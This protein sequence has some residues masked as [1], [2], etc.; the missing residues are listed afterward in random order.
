MF[1]LVDMKRLREGLV[2]AAKV[3][4]CIGAVITTICGIANYFDNGKSPPKNQNNQCYESSWNQYDGEIPQERMYQSD[5]GNCSGVG[6]I[7]NGLSNIIERIK[8]NRKRKDPTYMPYVPYGPT[9][10]ECKNGDA[11]VLP[12]PILTHTQKLNHQNECMVNPYYAYN[13]PYAIMQHHQQQYPYY[14]YNNLGGNNMYGNNFM[15]YENYPLLNNT[16][17]VGY[18]VDFGNPTSY[19]RYNYMIEN[20]YNNITMEQQIRYAVSQIPEPPKPNILS[21]DINASF[22]NKDNYG[23]FILPKFFNQYDPIQVNYIKYMN[24]VNNCINEILMN[25]GNIPLNN[26]LYA[27][28]NVPDVNGWMLCENEGGI[29][30]RKLKNVNTGECYPIPNDFIIPSELSLTMVAQLYGEQFKRDLPSVNSYDSSFWNTNK[31]YEEMLNRTPQ[32]YKDSCVDMGPQFKDCKFGDSLK[33]G[34]F[35]ALPEKDSTIYRIQQEYT[36]GPELETTGL[37]DERLFAKERAEMY[38]NYNNTH[39]DIVNMVNKYNDWERNYINE[40]PYQSLFLPSNSMIP[41]YRKQNPF[42]NNNNNPIW[43][44]PNFRFD[45]LYYNNVNPMCRAMYENHWRTNGI[46]PTTSNNWFDSSYDVL[47][48]NWTNMRFDNNNNPYYGNTQ[49]FGGP[50]D[51]SYQQMCQQ[52]QQN[53]YSLNNMN[54]SDNPYST[55]NFVSP[56]LRNLNPCVSSPYEMIQGLFADKNNS[57]FFYSDAEMESFERGNFNTPSNHGYMNLG[58][59]LNNNKFIETNERWQNGRFIV[60]ASTGVKYWVSDM[61]NMCINDLGNI[62]ELVVSMPN[63]VKRAEAVLGGGDFATFNPNLNNTNPFIRNT[64][65]NPNGVSWSGTQS[66]LNAFVGGK[67]VI[68]PNTHEPFQLANGVTLENIPTAC[69]GNYELIAGLHANLM[70]KVDKYNDPIV[71]KE[72]L[73]EAYDVTSNMKNNNEITCGNS[74]KE[75]EDFFGNQIKVKN[76]KPEI[77]HESKFDENGREIIKVDKYDN[78]YFRNYK[79]EEFVD[80]KGGEI[81]S[82]PCTAPLLSAEELLRNAMNNPEVYG[83]AIKK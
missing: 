73:N 52:I 9:Q 37:Y 34:Y 10:Y 19:A 4:G 32:I 11:F 15:G 1:N 62:D 38:R 26:N 64:M 49:I 66:P 83:N 67:I 50:T 5:K 2:V 48:N 63:H 27:K 60:N 79:G 16:N 80:Y 47:S 29:P 72:M 17:A 75:V 33:S 25:H 20:N 21:N 76:D 78:V 14:G 82:T 28:G 56:E 35:G 40:S 57:K 46:N 13:N 43:A 39:S 61:L 7:L 30:K 74:F 68:D 70:R 6:G 12:Q 77:K 31:N 55:L 42:E 59:M 8:E 22:N 81:E 36:R 45:D 54:V 69:C 3:I 44:Q 65:A 53:P 23:R 24:Q 18:G 41:D 71:T 51:V 58:N